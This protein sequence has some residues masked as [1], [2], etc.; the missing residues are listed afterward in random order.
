MMSN[1]VPADKKEPRPP[2]EDII[3]DCSICKVLTGQEFHHKIAETVYWYAILDRNPLCEGHIIVFTKIR[4]IRFENI[5]YA[6]M[7]EIGP[8]LKYI[9][10]AFIGQNWNI[11]LNNGRAAHQVFIFSLVTLSYIIYK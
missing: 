2:T 7:S 5:S 3:Q 9:G 10:K 8:L 1:I 6:E 11:L 4:H